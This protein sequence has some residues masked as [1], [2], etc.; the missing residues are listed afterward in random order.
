MQGKLGV[1]ICTGYGIGEALDIEALQKVAQD[2]EFIDVK[3]DLVKTVPS[4]EGDDLEAI[5]AE[6]AAEDLKN[7]VI[8]GPSARFYADDPFYDFKADRVLEFVNLREQVV[9]CQPPNEE[10]TQKMA[11]DYL[12]MGIIRATKANPPAP[13]EQAGQINKDILVVGG[14]I[15]GITA[16]TEAA[17][18]GYNVHLVEKEQALGGWMAK[19]HKSVPTK[20]PFKEPE[21]VDVAER[22][23][24]L[25][26]MDNVTIHT[27][28][29][30]AKIDG[31]PG[32]FEVSLKATGAEGNGLAT[33]TAGAIVQ[34]TGWRPDKPKHIDHLGFEKLPDVITNIQMEELARGGKI[35][36]P[37]DGKEVRSVAFVQVG[38]SPDPG[39]FS[40]CSSIVDLTAL[41]QALY[42][43]E[44]GDDRK[45]FIFYDHLRAPG[46]YED[47]YRAVQANPGVFL[48]KG[49][50]E[51]V[52][53]SGGKLVL[54]VKDT[55][56]AKALT[57]EVDLVVLGTGMK[58]IVADG[59]AI[60]QLRDAKVR[61]EKGESEDQRKAGAELVEKLKEHEGTSILNLNYRQGP[62]LPSLKYGYPDSHFICFP[63]ESRRTAIYPTGACRTPTDG[64]Q[65]VEDATGAAMKAIQ[66]VEMLSRGE[67]PHPRAGD[68]SFPDFFLQRCTQCKR[69][70]EECPF[71]ALNEDVK[72][73]PQPNPTRCRRCGICLGSC[74]E[75]IISFKNFSVDQIANVIKAIE[76]PEEFEEKPRFLVFACE[77][78]AYP[79]LDLAG[80]RRLRYSPFI[81]VIPVRC[82]GSMNPVWVS[83][84][85]SKGYDGI[86]LLGCKFG[87]DYQCHFIKGSELADY[88]GDNIREKLQQMA[89]ENERVQL[90]EI[91]IS[92]VDKVVQI[93]N[94]F[95][96]EI[97]GI[98]MNPFKGF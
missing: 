90:H 62:D 52:T 45:A 38:G 92:D 64:V 83:E 39:V 10:D 3:A 40:H 93:I 77:N 11:E 7:V 75:R 17:R 69:C 82:L 43:R 51:S 94:D 25:E 54:D 16:A 98:G 73:T 66:V 68:I 46:H 30:I 8:A 63:Y 81:R 32:M 72:G 44:Q 79:A 22:I 47:F 95:A 49:K 89:L 42:V 56:L 19:L 71:G 12:R 84:A 26:A 23:K 33:F 65:A 1:Y 58:P 85:L 50:V 6:I 18:A 24:A 29:E 37:S 60:R 21:P 31:A 48:T 55:M 97:T 53:A 86:L 61:A 41:K 70:T 14:G 74:P 78:D 57:V 67:A 80:Q 87:D 96:E 20:P 9:W 13:F 4:C 28:A 36:R 59:E 88:R 34:A 15:A 27:G 5:K 35:A 2:D 76:V 91:Q